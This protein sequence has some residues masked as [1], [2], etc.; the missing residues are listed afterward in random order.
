M[1]LNDL[2]LKKNTRR[3]HGREGVAI[4]DAISEEAFHEVK[5]VK[6][7]SGTRQ[8]RIMSDAAKHE[9]KKLKIYTGE[10][11]RVAKKL[12]DKKRENPIRIRR[13]PDLGPRGD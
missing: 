5:D 8:I 13:R 2:G 9:K 11:T 3:V 4:P 12:E 1:V 10:R 7:L 6:R